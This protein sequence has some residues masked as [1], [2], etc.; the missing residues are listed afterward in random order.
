MKARPARWNSELP[1]GLLGWTTTTP[2]DCRGPRGRVN[3][4][5]HCTPTRLRT[6]GFIVLRCR[7]FVETEPVGDGADRATSVVGEGRGRQ[8]LPPRV[9]ATPG[10]LLVVGLGVGLDRD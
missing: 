10:L 3:G 6:R 2:P 8:V 5:L 7:V 9:L 4:A 1:L